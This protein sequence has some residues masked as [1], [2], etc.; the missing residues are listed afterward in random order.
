MVNR[1]TIST[2]R[3]TDTFSLAIVHS[4][5]KWGIIQ[6]ECALVLW[7]SR[8]GVGT[9][10]GC[11]CKWSLVI[12]GTSVESLLSPLADALC[13]RRCVWYGRNM[14]A[15]SSSCSLIR[16]SCG[17]VC[18]CRS[19]DLTG[20]LFSHT[21]PHW[22]CHWSALTVVYRIERPAVLALCLVLRLRRSTTEHGSYADTYEIV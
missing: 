14:F 21:G 2:Q 12:V 18:S 20:V 16:R 10:E 8:P 3:V 17:R 5:M 19:I 15:K 13:D 6:D 11:C 1:A 4:L 7:I 22:M 9:K